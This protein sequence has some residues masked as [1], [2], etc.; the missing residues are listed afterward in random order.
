M[1]QDIEPT[2]RFGVN[3]LESYTLS[4]QALLNADSL[5]DLDE[6][7]VGGRHLLVV[8][9]KASRPFLVCDRETRGLVSSG[10]ALGEGPGEITSVIGVDF[11]PGSDTGWFLDFGSRS[12]NYVD[13]DS[14]IISKALPDMRLI[15][16][17][18]AT[19][20]S[21]VWLG[22]SS[23][24][25]TGFLNDRKLA[26]FSSDG[27]FSHFFGPEPPGLVDVP[28]R[29]RNQKYRSH[30]FGWRHDC[31]GESIHGSH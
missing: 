13:I 9:T 10:G 28:G 19:L 30:K 22:D 17:A 5:A 4:G 12:L 31:G 23:I 7:I 2:I 24:A 11:K 25:A 29:W 6:L 1:I 27:S 26:S 21:A 16:E 3:S 14:L 20:L 18:P 8:D 15:L